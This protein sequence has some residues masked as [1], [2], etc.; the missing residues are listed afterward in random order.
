MKIRTLIDH[1]TPLTV[2][3][4]D[5]LGLALQTMLWAEVR[6]LPVVSRGRLVGV[7]SERDL[8]AQ[9]AEVG[10]RRASRKRIGD[11]MTKPPIQ[12]EP[13]ETTARAA[14]LM[15]ERRIGALPVVENEKLLGIVT[16]SDLL[17][18]EA[19]TVAGG[20]TAANGL[21]VRHAMKERPATATPSDLLLDAVGRLR[22]LGVRHL[23]VVNGDGKLV[24][25]LSDRDVR[26]VI[27]DVN[28]SVDHRNASV[29]LE[30]M[31]V[32]HVMTR[33]PQSIS[34][35]A[36]LAEAAH[37]LV[38]TRVSALAVVDEQ[39]RLVGILSYVDILRAEFPAS[40]A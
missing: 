14:K 21:L 3:E 5:D 39:E 34:G 11:F 20:A 37:R 9:Q 7:V 24:G 36:P 40:A 10:T 30:S 16:R 13:D 29:R 23:P 19:A 28:R 12:I 1:Q 33:T 31:H 18:R 35:E 6:H 8:L 2:R 25:M 22:D 15:L 4:D 27:G 32:E 38:G 17:R 26:T